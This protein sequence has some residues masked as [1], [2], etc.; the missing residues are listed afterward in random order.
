M[1][2]FYLTIAVTTMLIQIAL[3]IRRD[4]GMGKSLVPFCYKTYREAIIDALFVSIK[5]G[6]FWP[7]VLWG[8]LRQNPTKP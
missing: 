6:T 8:Y 1:L 5:R 3:E 4:I 7:I 2:K